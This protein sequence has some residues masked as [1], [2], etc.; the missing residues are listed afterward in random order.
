[1]SRTTRAA[2]LLVAAALVGACGGGSGPVEEEGPTS[3]GGDGADIATTAAPPAGEAPTT[4]APTTAPPAKSSRPAVA[5]TNAPPTTAAAPSPA[6]PA[7]TAP[8]ATVAADRELGKG[9][10]GSFARHLLRP[11]PAKELV[12]ELLVQDGSG[13]S[14]AT[15]TKLVK[16]LADV[17]GKTVSTPRVALPGGGD[18]RYPPAEVVKLADQYGQAVQGG[19]QAVI[20]MLVLKGRSDDAN[21]LG[22][23]V[24]GDVLAVFPDQ[25]RQAETPLVDRATLEAA[26]SLHEIGHILGLVDLAR[27][28]GRED[29]EHPGHSSSRNSVMYWAVESTLV[30]QVLG[31]PP[32]TDFDAADLADLAALRAG[33]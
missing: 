11:A 27:K 19:D 18:G 15:R 8:P 26:L 12:L 22:F 6:S 24:R 20:R 21:V 32:P 16:V 30:G 33:G 17:S 14:E 2:A 3:Y 10:V 29:K 25:L 31:G 23:A 1:M 5:T 9:P 13:I 28:T 7:P 4:A